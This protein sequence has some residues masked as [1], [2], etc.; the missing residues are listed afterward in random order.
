MS[1]D[2]A[3]AKN[4]FH[5]KVALYHLRTVVLDLVPSN[6]VGNYTQVMKH[7]EI[8]EDLMRGYE[9][10]DPE[11]GPPADGGSAA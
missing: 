2:E 6:V 10:A 4:A 9:S 1:K 3:R 8:V 7:L 11:V 5:V